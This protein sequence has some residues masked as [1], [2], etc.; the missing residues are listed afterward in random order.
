MFNR[1]TC[2]GLA[3]A[4]GVVFAAGLF[5][6][7]VALEEKPDER[8]ALKGCEQRLCLMISK[9]ETTGADLQ[10]ALS[11][12]WAKNKIKEGIEKKKIEWSLGDARCGVSVEMK[13]ADIVGALKGG[14]AKIEMAKHVVKCSVEREKEV[15]PI[16]ISMSPKIEFK[17]GKA[18]KA[19]L[20]IT[21]I[22]APAV[23]KG[24]IWTA[25]K[26]EDSFGLFHSEMIKEINTFV[27]DK[28]P[29]RYDAEGVP[30]TR[31]K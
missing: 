28:C 24:A 20:G 22:E 5:A 30:K 13:R 17:D 19:W 18:V 4:A 12:T 2:A 15:I 9:K 11:K 27:Y 3:L 14:D 6:P 23:V 16:N 7:A 1:T 21:E 26:L 29:E 31:Q 10:C 25:A 8:E